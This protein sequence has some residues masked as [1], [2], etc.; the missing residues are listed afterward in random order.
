[1]PY[2]LSECLMPSR[3]SRLPVLYVFGKK[4]VDIDHCTETLVN[5][6]KSHAPANPQHA[7]GPILLRHD[8]AFTHVAGGY[9]LI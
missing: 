4:N 3:T 2:T 7:N 6:L 9:H 8:V 5:A 1:M